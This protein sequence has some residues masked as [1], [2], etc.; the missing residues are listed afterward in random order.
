MGVEAAKTSREEFKNLER[1]AYRTLL[2]TLFIVMTA[3]ILVIFAVILVRRY[4]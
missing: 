1:T 4:I 2:K 3:S